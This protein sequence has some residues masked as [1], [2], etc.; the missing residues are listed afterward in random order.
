MQGLNSP[1]AITSTGL[2]HIFTRRHSGLFDQAKQKWQSLDITSHFYIVGITI[3]LF[4]FLGTPFSKEPFSGFRNALMWAGNALFAAGFLFWVIP[5]LKAKWKTKAGKWIISILH[6]AVLFLAI[7]PSR[8]LVADALGLPPQ[9]FEMTVA[10]LT[11]L[12]YV[13]LWVV[14]VAA[15]TS[16][17][18]LLL[19]LPL[20][21]VGLL[22]PILAV[23]GLL[24]LS[25]RCRSVIQLKWNLI[26]QSAWKF[27]G[28]GVGAM[29]ICL[30]SWHAVDESNTWI[31]NPTLIKWV[32]YI[33]DFQFA[34]SYPG[35]D[36]AKRLRLHENNV[37]SYAERDDWNIKITVD[38]V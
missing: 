5:L 25:P 17:V 15:C 35:I 22:S 26:C 18:G 6:A 10:T 1:D 31:A 23:D 4:W 12:I 11:I 3:L 32:A 24:R 21:V 34:P 13:P 28:H 37:V 29:V 7:I 8:I 36:K 14:L 16:M 9:D 20:L 30:L 27:Y 33:S 19:L 38:R 2:A